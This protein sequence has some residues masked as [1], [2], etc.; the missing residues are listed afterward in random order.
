MMEAA[1]FGIAASEKSDLRRKEVLSE[2][3]MIDT[4]ADTEA[5]LI[6]AVVAGP[7]ARAI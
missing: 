3:T 2:D 4:T 1:D 5:L 7:M 6:V